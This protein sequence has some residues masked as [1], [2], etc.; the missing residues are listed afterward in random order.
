MVGVGKDEG[1]FAQIQYGL[2]GMI[3]CLQLV[4]L[5]DPHVGVDTGGGDVLHR[6]FST[7]MDAHG[8]VMG[9]RATGLRGNATVRE[10]CAS[11]ET[12]RT[13]T[14]YLRLSEQVVER[15]SGGT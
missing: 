14:S 3:K 8:C 13:P 2:V 11:S 7:R 9:Q 15:Y 10:Y 1:S 6:G 5:G 4:H 12:T